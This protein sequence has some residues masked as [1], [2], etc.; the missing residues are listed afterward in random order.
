M[1][2]FYVLKVMHVSRHVSENKSS[3]TS[4]T[5]VMV[6][7]GDN[8]YIGHFR[9]PATFSGEVIIFE[10]ICSFHY[11]C[12]LCRLHLKSFLHDFSLCRVSFRICY[13]YLYHLYF[14]HL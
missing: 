9:E 1:L 2:Q 5:S 3:T 4:E 10:F 11:L 6:C 14:F 8:G 13:L 12:D 7:I